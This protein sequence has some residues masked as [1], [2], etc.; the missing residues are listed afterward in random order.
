[1]R[2]ERLETRAML[3]ADLAAIAGVAS[4]SVSGTDE[5]IAGVVM[6]L[7]RDDGDGVFNPSTDVL[8]G[9]TTTAADGGY[10]FDHLLAG[11]YFVQQGAFVVGSVTLPAVAS[12]LI[13]VTPTDAEGTMHT[14]IDGFGTT[15]QIAKA[16]SSSPYAMSTAAASEAIGGFRKLVA[17]LD[18]PFGTVAL[19]ANDPDSG[20][21]RLDFSATAT[22]TGSRRVTWDGSGGA[23]DT[24]NFTGL[25]GIDLTDG[26][27]NTGIA[28]HI[29]ADKAGSLTMRLSTDAGNI[30]TASVP[31]PNT[32]GTLIQVILPFSSLIAT[33][34]TGAAL[35]T[36]GA[37]QMDVDTASAAIDG[38]IDD[39]GGVGPTVK[40]VNFDNKS[41]DLAITKTVDT[42]HPQVNGQVTFT[43]T[44]TNE[45]AIDATGVRVLDFLPAGLSF[46]S[47]QATQGAYNPVSGLWHVGTVAQAS[48]QTLTLV[49]TVT[50]PGTKT[51]TAQVWTAN[52]FDIDST[53]GNGNPAEDDLA[54]VSLTPKLIDLAVTKSVDDST[55]DVGHNVTFTVVVRN[56]GADGATGV[57]VLDFLPAGLS[58]VSAQATQGAYNPVS[59]LWHVGTVAQA[60]SQT[61]TLVAT[62]TTPGTKTNTAQVWT[63]NE[64]DIDS[65]PGNGN[66]TEDDLARV[67]LTPKLIDLAVTK[68]VDTP[69]P[70][71]NQSVNFTITVGNSGPDTAT[72]V[73]VVDLLPAGLAFQSSTASVGTY[74]SVTGLWSV[75]SLASG[76]S[77]TLVIRALVTTLGVKVNTA[78]VASANEYDIDSTPGNTVASEDDQASAQVVP[79]LAPVTPPV[80]PPVIPP[81]LPPVTPPSPI[82][83]RFNKLRFLAR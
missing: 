53:P 81:V 22:A 10:R 1:M 68:G 29:N 74:N 40:T 31:F 33:A 16:T 55:P 83:G 24:T 26:G 28:V 15:E 25:G 51:N 57:R 13:T 66:P 12:S 64:F 41:I 43:V 67:S 52:E 36:I 34:G 45:G 14:V 50:T 58:F 20:L 54:R 56:D 8:L 60:S 17:T 71:V 48:S 19:A 62:V 27:R 63:A 79:R 65:T 59:G 18:Q 6:T 23:A 38:Y 30:S 49:A 78:Q 21:S 46:V 4:L 35:T 9:S 61:L 70:L 82:P 5:A 37:I 2:F 75:G 3:A 77:G 32:F 47:G 73:S 7:H 11:S 80:V 69:D 76:Q 72:G 39:L 44:V 42:P